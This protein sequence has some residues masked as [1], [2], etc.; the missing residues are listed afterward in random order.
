MRKTLLAV[1]PFILILAVA[2]GCA[3]QASGN[4]AASQ[5]AGAVTGTARMPDGTSVQLEIVSYKNPGTMAQGLSYRDSLCP[6]CGMLFVFEK[7]GL[8]AFWM[9]DMRFSLDMIFL[10]ENFR[11]VDVARG[12]EPCGEVCI[13]YQSKHDAKYVLE[14]NG[15]FAA[16]HG[17]EE[18]QRLRI[19]YN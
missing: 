10:D 3:Q 15:G 17:L 9:P 6:Q 12:M 8:Q 18:G 14:V 11:V 13:P 7:P 5:N 16:A 4:A 1:L 2:A 19:N